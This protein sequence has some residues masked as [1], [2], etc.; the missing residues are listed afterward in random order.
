[1]A[2][3][4]PQTL[5]VFQ[6]TMLWTVWAQGSGKKEELSLRYRILLLRAYNLVWECGVDRG[7]PIAAEDGGNIT[8]TYQMRLK[9]V[10]LENCPWSLR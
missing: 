5:R 8:S 9:G 7:G 2:S 6:L 10:Q 3:I 4:A 1:M